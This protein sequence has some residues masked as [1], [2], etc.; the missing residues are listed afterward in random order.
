MIFLNLWEN[1]QQIQ[2]L[3]CPF[4]NYG[5]QMNRKNV[6]NDFFYSPNEKI[7]NAF[8]DSESLVWRFKSSKMDMCIVKFVEHFSRDP[9]IHL[10]CSVLLLNVT[11][12]TFRRSRKN[13][14]FWRVF[15]RSICDYR[16]KPPKT[17]KTAW[18]LTPKHSKNNFLKHLK[19]LVSDTF[20]N[21]DL[22]I[23]RHW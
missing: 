17:R 4:W 20:M 18:K 7:K 5:G 10:Q 6:K 13:C 9:K 14:I 16:Y 3:T 12:S 1:F 23:Y 22:F 2:V 8:L 21:R 11:I 15:E 19:F